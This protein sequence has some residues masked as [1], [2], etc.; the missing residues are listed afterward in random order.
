[1]TAAELQAQLSNPEIHTIYID[2]D[3]ITDKP[4]VMSRRNG[5]RNLDIV[6][7][8]KNYTITQTDPTKN[9][10]EFNAASVNDMLINTQTWWSFSNLTFT[11]GAIAISVKGGYQAEIKRCVFNHQRL[12]AIDL[13]LCLQTIIE[14][15][16]IHLPHKDGIILSTGG[17]TGAGAA[18]SQ[19][20]STVLNNVHFYCK[21]GSETMLKIHSTNG[22]M[23]NNAIFEGFNPQRCI[24][25]QGSST[26]A[27]FLAINNTHI[28][29]HP[30]DAAIYH[31]I[32][33]NIAIN[34][35]QVQSAAGFR[36]FHMANNATKMTVDN[37][38]QMP[39]ACYATVAPQSKI[40]V[41][42]SVQQ[43]YDKQF[44]QRTD[45]V[46]DF[47]AGFRYE[48]P[49]GRTSP[50]FESGNDEPDGE[51]DANI[52]ANAIALDALIKTVDV[53]RNEPWAI[54]AKVNANTWGETLFS[55]GMKS[56][57]AGVGTG[58]NMVRVYSTTNAAG[59]GSIRLHM[60]GQS[61]IDYG[62]LFID[63]ALDINTDYK[64]YLHY[65]GSKFTA[66][67]IG[68]NQRQYQSVLWREKNFTELCAGCYVWP[69]RPNGFSFFNGTVGG[70]L[71][72]NATLNEVY[73]VAELL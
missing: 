35:M 29:C 53:N 21:D 11:G 48:S 71:L 3:I 34:G 43:V 16:F 40:N 57:V 51:T 17:V 72:P 49:Y 37:L 27:R 38:T 14:R 61:T 69:N 45:G 36:L 19:C 54:I 55:L 50:D 64:I 46:D 31:E 12:A 28:E 47:P 58:Y 4:F 59:Q 68:G 6:G 33:G 63:N 41:K 70:Y 73:Q 65:D 20:N 52:L 7:L 5:R 24:S 2:S 67:R 56:T 66:G 10:F 32:S 23:V 60:V 39:S 42:N 30:I 13:R 8:H 26:H 22:C 9:I 62:A 44:W 18:N 15:C 1:M 25:F